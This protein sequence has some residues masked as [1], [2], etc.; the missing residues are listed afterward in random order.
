MAP[1]VVMA[2]DDDEL[3]RW[4]PG[5]SFFTMGLVQDRDA[6]TSTESGTRGRNNGD[7]LGFPWTIGGS[8]E[9]LTP[10]LPGFEDVAGRPRFFVHGDIA[11]GM[12][13]EDPVVSEGDPGDAPVQDLPPPGA[14][15]AYRN[16]GSS[17]RAEAKPLV[18]SGGL[19]LA[20]D[21]EAWDRKFRV[22]PT[23][24]WLYQ[25]DTM[26]IAL[27]AVENEGT[28]NNLCGPCRTTF[29]KQQT[30][31]GFHSIGPG[32]DIDVEAA[33]AGN[34]LVTFFTSGRIYSIVGD[35][36]AQLNATGSWTN[37]DGSPT[38]A[39]DETFY[40]EYKRERWHYRFGMGIRFMWMPE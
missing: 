3:D 28:G 18:L 16:Q 22:R 8:L 17:V 10:T 1:S 25:R 21:F 32:I 6:T 29:I 5:G 31:K 33:R 40:T 14:P 2:A 15:A 23:L 36:K 20:F 24:E 27:G 39:P 37:D 11:Y 12:D 34:F 30:E 19:G 4:I 38:T 13:S 7:S 35:R 9:L 26:K